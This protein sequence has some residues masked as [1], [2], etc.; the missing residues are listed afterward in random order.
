MM[1]GRYT[2]QTP[3]KNKKEYRRVDYVRSK[4][5]HFTFIL[6]GFSLLI[7]FFIHSII[8]VLR[9]LNRVSFC[10]ISIKL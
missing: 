7:S 2:V 4:N 5:R 1:D 6:V 3:V 9:I 10:V 8:N